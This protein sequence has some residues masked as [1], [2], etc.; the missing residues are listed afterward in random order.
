MPVI[1]DLAGEL[2]STGTVSFSL[3]ASGN[4]HS[5]F[6]TK[7]GLYNLCLVLHVQ[8]IEKE[9]MESAVRVFEDMEFRFL[10]RESRI[11]E[12]EGESEAE[13]EREVSLQQHAVN[14]AQERVLQLEKQVKEM[15]REKDK[16]LNALK[17]ERRELLHTSHRVSQWF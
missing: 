15:E 3:L 5:Q 10:E 13:R 9:A 4:L 16:E 2:A 7:F 17:Q 11:E 6:K 8:F 12:E 1:L 14:T